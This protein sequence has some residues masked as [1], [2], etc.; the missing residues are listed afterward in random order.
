MIDDDNGIDDDNNNG[1]NDLLLTTQANADI[2]NSVFV[3]NTMN[4]TH[5]LQRLSWHFA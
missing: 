1:N 3:C 5:I 4:G 2:A